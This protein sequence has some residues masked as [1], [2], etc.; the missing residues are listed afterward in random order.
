MKSLSIPHPHPHLPFPPSMSRRST[1]AAAATAS[2]AISISEKPAEQKKAKPKPKSK[3]GRPSKAAA[4]KARRPAAP[5]PAPSTPTLPTNE[6]LHLLDLHHHQSHSEILHNLHADQNASTSYGHLQEGGGEVADGGAVEGLGDLSGLGMPD[7]N[8][9]FWA[10]YN[11][12][13][14]AY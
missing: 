2:E 1:R 13:S 5:T 10:E 12:V 7:A 14:S 3:A 6:E 4:S 9:A 11:L 8:H